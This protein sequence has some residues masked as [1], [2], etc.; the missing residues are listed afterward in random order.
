MGLSSLFGGPTNTAAPP[1]V[2]ANDATPFISEVSEPV[3]RLD[4]DND[5]KRK[6][7][8]QISQEL[9]VENAT[10]LVEKISN[11]CFEKCPMADDLCVNQC[12]EKYM[13]SWNIIS[14]TYISRIQKASNGF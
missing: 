3:T 13:R 2:G 11:N 7:K 9:A 4:S 8:E 14:K 6:L 12:L 1:T 10:L 5:F